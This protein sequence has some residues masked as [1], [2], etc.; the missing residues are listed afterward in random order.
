MPILQDE[1]GYDVQGDSGGLVPRFVDLDLGSSL[2]LLLI[3]LSWL[4]ISLHS[5]L[6]K[7]HFLVFL[8]FTVV[9]PALRHFAGLR[10]V[11]LRHLLN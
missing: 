5:P 10:T 1:S 9:V 11:A 7:K 6:Y 2:L 3:F 8:T 4:L